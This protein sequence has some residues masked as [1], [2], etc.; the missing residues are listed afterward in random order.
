VA[1]NVSSPITS[2]TL[3]D[4]A[5]STNTT[6]VETAAIG[7][8]SDVSQPSPTVEH[9]PSPTRIKLILTD[10]PP[11]PATKVSST[12]TIAPTVASGVLAGRIVFVS[13]RDQDEEIYIMNADGTNQS[14]LTHIQYGDV[15]PVLSPDGRFI[16]FVSQRAGG[17]KL[18]IMSSDG[19]N[20]HQLTDGKSSVEYDPYFSPDGDWIA[21]SSSRGG[22]IELWLIHPDG[23][24]LKQLTAGTNGKN[25]PAWSPDG[26]WIAYNSVQDGKDIIKISRPDGT[27]D[28][29]IR[30][31]DEAYVTGWVGERI[32]FVAPNGATTDIYSMNPDGSN[33]RQLT[34]DPAGDKGAFGTLDGRFIIFNSARDGD[35]EIYVM[36]ADGSQQTR[37]TFS[38]GNDYMPTWGP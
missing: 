26:Q 1:G 18:F 20:P 5:S 34:T 24:G 2:A 15:E 17:H 19:S 10:T 27:G 11:P 4:I 28:K 16:V 22:R 25:Y 33:V 8:N 38:S 14:R 30:Q 37:I 31:Q 32:L 7:N 23:T 6:T 21:Y 13:Y 36:H 9:I 35:D 12:P 29:L 3:A